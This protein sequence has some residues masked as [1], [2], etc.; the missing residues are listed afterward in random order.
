MRCQQ[1]CAATCH[2]I[3]YIQLQLWRK[4]I[5]NHS[6]DPYKVLNLEPCATFE[7]VKQK[8]LFL[9]KQ[10][11]PDVL[12]DRGLSQREKSV[13]FI[14]LQEA[15][16]KLEK[17]HS[18]FSRSSQSYRSVKSWFTT[19]DEYAKEFK[20]RKG[21]P[22]PRCLRAGNNGEYPCYIICDGCRSM[23]SDRNV[24]WHGSNDLYW[25]E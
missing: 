3:Q 22:T 11:H 5:H 19:Y 21:A 17:I 2:H 7:Q 1:T 18:S 6:K 9:V 12:D 15:Y 4:F 8:Y 13:A 10:I 23:C 20:R 24:D 14:E 25:K 16:K